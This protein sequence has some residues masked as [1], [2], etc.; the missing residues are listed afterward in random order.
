[1]AGSDGR[2]SHSTE[3]GTAARIFIQAAKVPASIFS[4]LLKAQKT[5]PSSGRPWSARR[6]GSGATAWR[7]ALE[8]VSGRRITASV[9]RSSS[10]SGM[11]T[12]SPIT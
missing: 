6:P 10:A 7:S 5:I 12:G 1:V 11:T 3:P 4:G 8:K 9:K 2:L